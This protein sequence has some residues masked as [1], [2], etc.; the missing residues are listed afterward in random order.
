MKRCQQGCCVEQLEELVKLAKGRKDAAFLDYQG[1]DEDDRT[2][3]PYHYEA[4]SL[5]ALRLVISLLIQER[6]P[7]AHGEIR[8]RSERRS[9]TPMPC[10][11][12][13]R[14]FVDKEEKENES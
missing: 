11:N 3:H 7:C 14:V 10:A 12:R 2:D 4:L 8:G 13:N 1:A 5:Y 9:Q 6:G